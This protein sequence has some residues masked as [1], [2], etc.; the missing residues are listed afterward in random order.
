MELNSDINIL[1]GLPD[2]ALVQHCWQDK[3][4]RNRPQAHYEYSP[5]RTE[6]AVK[7]FESAINRTFLGVRN[8]DVELMLNS[9]IAREGISSDVK[10]FLFWNAAANND[11]FHLMNASVFFPALYSGRAVLR[12]ADAAAYL[13]DLQRTTPALAK[14]SN[15]TLETV[16]S[17]YLT[18]LKK[19]GLMEGGVKKRLQT[20][21]LSDKMVILFTYWLKAVE[22]RPNLLESTW[23]PYSL[24]EQQAFVQRITQKRYAKVIDFTFTG[25]KLKITPLLSFNDVY[26]AASSF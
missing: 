8:P 1:G 19:L 23:L 2:L 22:E 10:Q 13:V 16:A 6:K 25:D 18:L 4:Y 9:M 14:W 12:V 7:R 15:L 26:D 21:F 3:V 20:P 5:I 24:S 17:K 11:L